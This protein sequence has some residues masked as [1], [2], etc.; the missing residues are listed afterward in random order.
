MSARILPPS[1]IDDVDSFVR[2]Q[3]SDAAKF[4]NSD[5][6]DESGVWSLHKLAAEIYAAGWADG[7]QAERRRQDGQRARERTASEVQS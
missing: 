6:L 3:L 1:L 2:R 4:D 7:E 5:V